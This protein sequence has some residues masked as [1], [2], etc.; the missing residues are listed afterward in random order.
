MSVEI[1]TPWSNGNMPMKI[2]DLGKKGYVDHCLHMES[3]ICCGMRLI[4]SYTI[5]ITI[6]A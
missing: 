4:I 5:S 1:V 3:L 6:T 2:L